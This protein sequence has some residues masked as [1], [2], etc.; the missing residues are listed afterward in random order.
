MTVRTRSKHIPARRKQRHVRLSL[1]VLEARELLDAASS[2]LGNLSQMR[3]DMTAS[4]IALVNAVQ[5][6]PTN[7]PTSASVQSQWNKAWNTLTADWN[8]TWQ[9]FVQVESDALGAIQQEFDTLLDALGI[10]LPSQPASTTPATV[11]SNAPLG[12]MN[13]TPFPSSAPSNGSVLPPVRPAFSLSDPPSSISLTSSAN[14]SQSG[15]SVTFTATVTG[16]SGTPTGTVTFYDGS[17]TVLGTGQLNG[18]GIATYATSSLTVGNHDITAIYSGDSTY[19]GSTN[20]VT[21]TVDTAIFTSGGSWVAPSTGTVAVLCTGGGGGGGAGGNAN[22]TQAAAGGGGGGG[23]IEVNVNVTSGNHY[24]IT[25]GAGGAGALTAGLHATGGI[26]GNSS[27]AFGS[28]VNCT[29]NGGGGGL[30]NL[31]EAGGAGGASSSGNGAVLVFAYTGGNGGGGG[32]SGGGGGGGGAGTAGT[33]PNAGTAGNGGAGGKGT[34][35]NTG[36]GGAA[37]TGG[38]G[39]GGVGGVGGTAPM[40]AGTT[41]S[42]LGGGGGGG[43]A[44]ANDGV[45]G[46]NGGTGASGEMVISS[47]LQ[48]NAASTITLSS[49]PNPSEY[50]Q[51]VTLTATVSG[52]SG[53]PTGS[54]TFYNGTTVLGT[55]TVNTSGI[56]TLNVSSLTVG[57]HDITAIYGGSSTYIGSTASLTQNVSVTPPVANPDSYSPP[58]DTTFSEPAAG[59]LANDVDYNGLSLSAVLVSNAGHGSVTLNSNGSFLYTP[60]AGFSG[61]DSFTYYATDGLANSNTTTVTLTVTNS[62]TITAQPDSYSVLHDQVLSVAASTG[63]LANDSDSDCD[64]L[65][66]VLATGPSHGTLQLNTDGSFTYTPNAGYVG[67]DSFTYKASDGMTTSSATTVTISVTDHAPTASNHSYGIPENTTVNVTAT[68]G[69]LVG[70]TDADSDPLTASLVAGH[71]PSHGPVT[72]H[73]DGS[74]T[75]TPTTGYTGTDNFTYAI[76]DGA[77]STDATV[78]LTIHADSSRP[79]AGSATYTVQHDQ[80]LTETAANGVL[81][82]ASDS[83]GDPLTASEVSGPSNGTLTLN[84]DGSFTYTPKAS[85]TDTDSFQYAASDGANTSAAATVT[86]NVTNTGAPVAN[87]DSYTVERNN[88]YYADSSNGVLANDSDSDGDTLTASLV[89]GPSHGTLTVNSDGSFDYVPNLNFTGTDTF[90]YTAS[91]GVQTSSPATVTLTVSASAP[92]AANESFNVQENKALNAPSGTLMLGDSN[93][94][95]M[96][97]TAQDVTHPSHGT[98][99]VNSNG[100]FVYTLSTNFTGTDSFTYDLADGGLTSAAATV[101]IT[102]KTSDTPPRPP[103]SAIRWKKT[104]VWSHTAVMVCS[105]TLR[106]ATGIHCW[107]RFSVVPA[108]VHS[109]SISMVHSRTRP[110]Q[111]IT[112]PTASSMK[113]STAPPIPVRPR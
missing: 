52:S 27:F 94:D 62:G 93:P 113:C 43:S 107:L 25:V 48:Q 2:F 47:S 100:S 80:T 77:E 28:T 97:L 31:P 110:T 111:T 96:T 54:V 46:G 92:S 82:H 67:S 102:V 1:E 53:T 87:P 14:P 65:T 60:N 10:H 29:A 58:H 23:A 89:S 41:G 24:T 32:A 22:A 88:D 75:Y 12:Q 66:A 56:A 71:G 30:A 99:T 20:W 38:S 55:G 81:A 86:I 108:T 50:A 18:S 76:S 106:T 51:S 91:D 68:S 104:I 109:N 74:F 35:G 26:G 64:P 59:V 61:T 101:T 95:N 44:T 45:S 79:T 83:D 17:T 103:T 33:A 3:H 15:Q 112:A 37:G 39:G 6:S 73:S 90:T 84:A 57:Y 34:A 63:V 78:T 70:A 69:L 36:A 98:V 9:A 49:S 19:T 72:V 5:S 16:N 4:T 7:T 85:W 21:Q 105:L 11:T 13:P 40:G 42:G 8:K